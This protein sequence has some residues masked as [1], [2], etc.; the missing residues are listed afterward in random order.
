MLT[1]MPGFINYFFSGF[2][3]K[4]EGT[5]IRLLSV[6]VVSHPI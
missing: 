5:T 3:R 2:D 1:F 6:K 4:H